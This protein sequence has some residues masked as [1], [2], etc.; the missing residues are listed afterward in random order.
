MVAADGPDPVEHVTR[1]EL[2]ETLRRSIQVERVWLRRPCDGRTGP[3]LAARL[4]LTA[5]IDVDL[6]FDAYL[7]SDYGE[8]LLGEVSWRAGATGTQRLFGAAPPP[9]L[10]A[11]AETEQVV[12]IELRASRAAAV[13]TLDCYRIWSGTLRLDPTPLSRRGRGRRP[14]VPAT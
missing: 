5:P 1:P 6:V 13:R 7:L 8:A 3:H 9:G 14:V 4:N 2:T 10:E 12:T 11:D